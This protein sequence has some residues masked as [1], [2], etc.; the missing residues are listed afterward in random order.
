[1]ANHVSS[2]KR[3]RRIQEWKLL[4]RLEKTELDLLLKK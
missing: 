1:M 2:K 3:I 4:T